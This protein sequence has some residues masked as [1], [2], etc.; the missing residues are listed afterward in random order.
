M[1]LRIMTPAEL[2]K[3]YETD[4]REAFPPA[5]LKPLRA[6]EAMRE[7]GVY[8]PL[9]LYGGDGEVLGYI[10]LWKHEDGRYILI[11]YLCVP[12][13][14]RNGG[15]GGRMLAAVRD[16]YPPETVFL[17]E[18]EAPLG[19][20][21]TDPLKLRRLGFY[22]RSGAVTLGYD[23]ALFGVHYKTLCWAAPLPDEGEILRKHQ[24]IY[25][26]QFGR[27]R[28]EQFIQLPLH[29]GES[30]RPLTDWVE[31]ID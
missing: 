29:P 13:G 20:P 27:E 10:L 2:K 30:P 3:A 8:D 17:G 12:A 11:D 16:F 25:L 4:L 14:R 18:S 22:A 9:G 7:R 23:C 26:E 21:D 31:D 1:H 19:D 24:E 28:Y 6:M 5:E 15:T